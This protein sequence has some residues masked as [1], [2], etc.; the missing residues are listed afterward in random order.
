MD[1]AYDDSHP[2]TLNQ[3]LP[4]PLLELKVHVP[5]REEQVRLIGALELFHLRR[6][7][8]AAAPAP[9]SMPDPHNLSLRSPPHKL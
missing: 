4:L 5:T 3:L 1:C 7:Q 6:V 8:G 9:R 2:P